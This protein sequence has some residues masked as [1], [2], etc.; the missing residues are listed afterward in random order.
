MLD[1][2]VG[3][4]FPRREGH[5]HIGCLFRVKEQVPSIGD[6]VGR[7]PLGDLTPGMLGPIGGALEDPAAGLSFEDDV[8][9][10]GFRDCVAARPPQ[11]RSTGPHVE[12]VFTCCVD[13]EL[14]D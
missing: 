4:R 10:L 12:G 9:V 13:A 11:P 2:D 8:E 6:A 3:S 1:P 7:I 5:R 14:D